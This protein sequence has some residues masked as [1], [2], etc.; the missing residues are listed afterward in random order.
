[1][2]WISW[3]AGQAQGAAYDAVPSTLP[4]NYMSKLDDVQL[5]SGHP[6][7]RRGDSYE[8]SGGSVPWGFT[9]D[10]IF[11]VA[12]SN[13][14]AGVV[15]TADD[16]FW[17]WD[18]ATVN[19]ISAS[20]SP[21]ASS[22]WFM[23]YVG[24]GVIIVSPQNVPYLWAQSDAPYSPAI[25]YTQQAAWAWPANRRA[26]NIRSYQN[27]L[28]ALQTEEDDG[29]G[30]SVPA[31]FRVRWSNPGG[32]VTI[33][34]WEEDLTV[35][36]TTVAS[37]ID[38]QTR[39][40]ALVDQR[41]FGSDNL[42]FFQT[43]VIRMTYQGAADPINIFKF[44][45]FIEDDGCI[46]TGA[47]A[48]TPDGVVVV[49][50]RSIYITNGAVKRDIDYDTNLGSP[51][52]RDEIYSRIN[53]S[54][55]V[56]LHYVARWKEV[57]LFCG[58]SS[59]D[60]YRSDYCY[61]YNMERGGWS[62]MRIN[63]NNQIIN[64]YAVGTGFAFTGAANEV[65]RA[66]GDYL[67]AAHNLNNN[68]IMRLAWDRAT[69]D[70]LD[71]SKIDSTMETDWLDLQTQME[72]PRANVLWIREILPQIEGEGLVQIRLMAKQGNINST[73]STVYT[74]SFDCMSD[75]R[76]SVDIPGMRY[77]KLIVESLDT[78]PFTLIGYDLDVIVEDD[79]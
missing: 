63:D 7:S 42:L 52:V 5:V 20:P 49:G 28:I 47:T 48:V 57:Y 64:V 16:T 67:L 25:P 39:F 36:P 12:Q 33:P 71:G 41:V 43:G 54:E 29:G 44:T 68:A 30:G 46:A 75:F 76:L 62:R 78:K 24:A 74:E 2:A 17:Y 13:L 58:G 55:S 6:K 73:E 19:D 15:I 59:G 79:A 77:V 70:R 34:T 66:A 27:H 9:V 38:L 21:S 18:G 31:N 1:M 72:Q 56:K 11:G 50:Q 37:Y 61:I 26:V 65:D 32:I 3:R 22:Q 69:S 51:T 40:G 4:Q 8:I 60:R 53:Q 35:D 45:T 14:R 23:D 10:G